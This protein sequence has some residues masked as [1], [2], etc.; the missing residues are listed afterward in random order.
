VNEESPRLAEPDVAIVSVVEAPAKVGAKLLE[1]NVP[2]TP[3]GRLET[4]R[5]MDGGAEEP[6]VSVKVTVYVVDEPLRTVLSAGV[7]ETV[8]S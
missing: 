5:P 7:T 6:D 2:V 4:V 8:K 3:E 1:A